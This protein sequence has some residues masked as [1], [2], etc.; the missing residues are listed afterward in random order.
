MSEPIQPTSNQ[1]LSN[2]VGRLSKLYDAVKIKLTMAEQNELWSIVGNLGNLSVGRWATD[3]SNEPTVS[4]IHAVR[5]RPDNAAAILKRQGTEIER[6]RA[7]L[8]LLERC[9]CRIVERLGRRIVQVSWNDVFE[10]QSAVDTS[11]EKTGF[12]RWNDMSDGRRLE[13]WYSKAREIERAT[14]I[15]RRAVSWLQIKEAAFATAKGPAIIEEMQRFIAGSPDETSRDEARDAARYRW[16]RANSLDNFEQRAGV[17][18]VL[19]QMGDEE[20]LLGGDELD[21]EIDSGMRQSVEET[22]PE[23]CPRCQQTMPG[24]AALHSDHCPVKLFPASNHSP[25]CGAHDGKRCDCH[26]SKKASTYPTGDQ[27]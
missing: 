12:Q 24:G 5:E 21:S 13:D 8:A 7:D 2:N 10:H 1:Y 16:L 4:E 20:L 15:M 3:A 6:L 27:S 22:G 9:G 11:N 26:L 18:F 19:A 25:A 23:L 14:R 17:P